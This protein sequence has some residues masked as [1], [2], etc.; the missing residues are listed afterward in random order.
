EGREW[1][2]EVR[3]RRAILPPDLREDPTY[4]LNS[5]NW[6]S[7]GTWEFDAR[8]RAA[9]LADVDY[10][11]REITAEEEENDQEDAD[12]DSDEDE[13]EH[14]DVTMAQYDHDD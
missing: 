13:D 12:E 4:A 9:Y 14:E 6:I 8:R 3:R 1:R 5:Y 7:F 11:E 10:F 2:D